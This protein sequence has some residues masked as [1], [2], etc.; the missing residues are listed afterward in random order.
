MQKKAGWLKDIFGWGGN[1]MGLTF[2]TAALGGL[3]GGYGLA[4]LTEPSV[5]MDKEVTDRE[6][7]K[8]AL[9][10]EIDATER[11]IAELKRKRQQLAAARSERPYDRF[12]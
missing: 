5:L 7:V 3:A 2:G 12:V 6:L 10:S 8:E 4:K 9:E 1:Y 11:R